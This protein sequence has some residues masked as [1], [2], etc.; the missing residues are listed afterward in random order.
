MVPV[1]YAHYSKIIEEIESVERFIADRSAAQLLQGPSVDR[2]VTFGATAVN[3]GRQ[4]PSIHD[5]SSTR[6][7]AMG[8]PAIVPGMTE[9]VAMHDS[10][11][12][13]HDPNLGVHKADVV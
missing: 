8:Y 13:Y 2:H 4:L 10:L 6:D 1:N 3:G 9:M 12:E 7:V 5:V 11:A